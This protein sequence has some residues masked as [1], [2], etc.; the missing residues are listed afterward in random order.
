MEALFQRVSGIAA[1][2]GMIAFKRLKS[3]HENY[4]EQR[5]AV[6]TFAAVCVVFLGAAVGL[7]SSSIRR[8][9]MAD[10]RV[11]GTLRAVGA[12]ARTIR[13]CYSGTHYAE[14]WVRLRRGDIWAVRTLCRLSFDQR[15][16]G[17]DRWNAGDGADDC[18]GCLYA[19]AG[20]QRTHSDEEEHH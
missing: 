10:A 6:I 1:R 5:M 20:A 7:I 12:N 18:V 2:G 16:S 8:R 14:A 3:R 13:G 4:Q 17:A 9:V 19:D 15:F 11:I